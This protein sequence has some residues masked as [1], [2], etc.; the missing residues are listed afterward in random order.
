MLT[1]TFPHCLS[2]TESVYFKVFLTVLV[3]SII[4]AF[5]TCY[6]FSLK[7]PPTSFFSF[8]LVTEN[9]D[10]ALEIHF[11]K[12]EEPTSCLQPDHQ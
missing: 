7:D 6:F 12:A 9:A 11:N 8:P 10:Q 5:H 2:P 1:H 4:K 3:I